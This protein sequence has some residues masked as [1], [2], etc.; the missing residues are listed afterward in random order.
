MV[1]VHHANVHNYVHNLLSKQSLFFWNRLP[2]ECI[3]DSEAMLKMI[4]KSQ[5]FGNDFERSGRAKLH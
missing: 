5:C 1:N 2:D 3:F 4:M